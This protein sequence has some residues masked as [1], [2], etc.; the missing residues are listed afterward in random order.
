MPAV[1]QRPLLQQAEAELLAQA[2]H[3]VWRREVYPLETP[4]LEALLA[5]WPSVAV[6]Q[7]QVQPLL[8]Q[9]ELLGEDRGG[10]EAKRAQACAP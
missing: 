4:P 8:Y 3:D 2:M 1:P 9:A 10:Q 5:V 7:Q 6:M